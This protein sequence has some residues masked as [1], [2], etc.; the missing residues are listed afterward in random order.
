VHQDSLPK[1]CGTVVLNALDSP[2]E[3]PSGLSR[4]V[5]CSAIDISPHQDF[6]DVIYAF[7]KAIDMYRGNTDAVNV[8]QMFYARAAQV[9]RHVLLRMHS[10][11][12]GSKQRS[13][14]KWMNLSL[15]M[16]SMCNEK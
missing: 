4:R 1:I 16:F 11:I 10:S 9:A 12:T 2:D 3:E 5:N 6:H 15:K 8:S 7:R 13:G 14:N